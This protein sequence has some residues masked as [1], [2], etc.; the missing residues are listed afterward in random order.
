MPKKVGMFLLVICFLLGPV[1]MSHAETTA[2]DYENQTVFEI[3]SLNEW[4]A[5]AAIEQ[6]FSGKTVKLTADINA[7]GSP[8]TTLFGAGFAGTFDGQGFTISNATT[9]QSLIAKTTKENAL[10]KNIAIENVTLNATAANSG[11]VVG[12]V[13]GDTEISTLELKD[14]TVEHSQT[15]T[16]AMVGYVSSGVKVTINNSS[17]DAEVTSG[18]MSGI[19]IGAMHG[20]ADVDTLTVTGSITAGKNA[21][22]VIG[23][24][25]NG[26]IVTIKNVSVNN[27][28]VSTTNGSEAGLLIGYVAG[29]NSISIS[30]CN[31]TGNV[32]VLDTSAGGAIGALNIN[33]DKNVTLQN[34]KANVNITSSSGNDGGGYGGLIGVA[35]LNGSAA[36]SLENCSSNGSI[37]TSKGNT[38]GLIGFSVIS[39]HTGTVSISKCES[40]MEITNNTPNAWHG[41]GSLI[42]QWGRTNQ[43]GYAG[44]LRISNCIAAGELVGSMTNSSGQESAGGIIGMLSS[45]GS[46]NAIVDI[47]NCL[48][49]TDINTNL[50]NGYSALVIGES[51]QYTGIVNLTDLS[52]TKEGNCIVIYNSENSAGITYNGVAGVAGIP[53]WNGMER[54]SEARVTGIVERDSSGNIMNIK[55]PSEAKY[56]FKFLEQDIQNYKI[57]LNSNSTE[58]EQFLAAK[59]QEKINYLSG[60][61]LEIISTTDSTDKFV[62]TKVEA[63]DP[64]S[65]SIVSDESVVNINYSNAISM[66]RAIIALIELCETANAEPIN[67]GASVKTEL[68]VNKEDNALVRV[69]SSNVLNYQD[70]ASI[71]SELS[72][73]TRMAILAEY[74]VLYQ[75]DFIGVQE[76]TSEQYPLLAAGLGANYGKVIFAE[77]DPVSLNHMFYRADKYIMEDSGYMPLSTSQ[78]KRFEWAL[79]KEIGTDFRLIVM[80]FHG[81]YRGSDYRV[82]EA[83]DINAVI[84]GIIAE[85]PNV[86]IYF[87]GDYNAAASS[88]E[89]ATLIEGLNMQSGMLVA[90]KTD[91]NLGTYHSIGE[92]TVTANFAIDHITVTYNLTDVKLY[93]RLA[94]ELLAYASDHYPVFIDSTKYKT[95]E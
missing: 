29:N 67:L 6:D 89:F 39:A 52:T 87:T 5:L 50:Q 13:S 21:A 33:A 9:S 47:S 48:I 46:A 58:Y 66:H 78:T 56:N 40:S 83:A 35:T 4:T 28:N 44:T 26:P 54:I 12:N 24:L 69:M 14:C 94:D 62:F 57:V 91:G 73:Q 22:A 2:L 32:S 71:G 80:N 61:E 95:V 18:N 68:N 74:Y 92:T 3:G 63:E 72:Y 17:V 65:Y 36:L 20:D 81:N 75:P 8:L 41:T 70:N 19:V 59:F 34:V 1:Y 45:K 23:R 53:E 55:K 82:T 76:S 37:I 27:A 93:R 84:D 49:T 31:I 85:Y 11:I 86:P 77:H 38:G 64:Y 15:Y 90:E 16:G 30:N 42:G 10:I 60:Y 88:A 51:N 43:S 79:F 25:N 7:Q